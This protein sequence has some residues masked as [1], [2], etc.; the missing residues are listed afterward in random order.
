MSV[1][2]LVAFL[3]LSFTLSSVAMAAG[4][5][6]SVEQDIGNKVYCMCGCAVPLNICADPQCSSKAEMHQIV[7]TDL[8]EG[9]T[10]PAVLQNLVAVYGEKV[11]AS[12]PPRGFNLTAWILPGLG[13][14]LGLFLVVAVMRRWRRPAFEAA[15]PAPTVNHDVRATVEEKMKMFD[16]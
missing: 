6:A 12:P 14:I 10:E 2:R 13:L 16:E 1:K 8:R 5:L 7:R 15:T 4:N 11:L 3:I 9:K